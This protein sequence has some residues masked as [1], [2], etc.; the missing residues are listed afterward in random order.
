M[1]GHNY[2]VAIEWPTT[3]HIERLDFAYKQNISSVPFL[4]LADHG[5]RESERIEFNLEIC[6]ELEGFLH[7]WTS[8]LGFKT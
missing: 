2:H 7:F 5:V 1:S 3:L 6:L 4:V 8:T